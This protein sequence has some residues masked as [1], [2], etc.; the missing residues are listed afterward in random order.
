MV[1]MTDHD[2]PKESDTFS[3][4]Y[5]YEMLS[6][7]KRVTPFARTISELCPGKVV[8][9]SG[10]GTG[11]LSILAARAGAAAVYCTEIDPIVAQFARR[12]FEQSG[13]AEK[14]TLIP[15]STLHVTLDDLNGHRPDVLIAENL[16]T[17]QVMEPQ[18]QVM[19]HLR[20]HLGHQG[21]VSIPEKAFNYVQLGQ[22]E[23]RF[24]D[25]VELK[26]PYYEFAGI[27]SAVLRSQPTLFS[28]FDYKGVV[29][30][31]LEKEVV[32]T[33]WSRGIVNS[34]RLTS[35]LE[36]S[37]DNHF[38]YSDSLMPPVVVP[39]PGDIEVAAGEQFVVS[40]RYQT[41]AQWREFDC[42]IRRLK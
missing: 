27:R 28:T 18:N 6:D 42:S 20:L 5:H 1:S 15:K 2:D 14:I 25:T 33:A 32:V 29:D 35:P 17:W 40:I 21:T 37:K 36:L 31:A 3:L 7:A 38:E 39:L 30:T 41:Y 22:S 9:E 23:Y 16:A 12:N 34:L 26:T 13:F 19:N 10:T 24:F 8:F 4:M 11:V